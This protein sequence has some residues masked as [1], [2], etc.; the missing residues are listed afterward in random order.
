MEKR[1]WMK[2]A[3]INMTI[4]QQNLFSQTLDDTKS[5]SKNECEKKCGTQTAKW[6]EGWDGTKRRSE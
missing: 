4:N 6:L 2:S 3:L 1:D 5:I